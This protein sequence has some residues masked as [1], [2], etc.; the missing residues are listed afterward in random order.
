MADILIIKTPERFVDALRETLER[1]VLAG[2]I[3]AVIVI[4]PRNHHR[5]FGA[6][7]LELLTG[8]K[9]SETLA[10]LIQ[11]RLIV[12]IIAPVPVAINIIANH[13]EQVCLLPGELGKRRACLLFIVAGGN[14]NAT[15]NCR[16]ARQFRSV[17]CPWQRRS[18]DIFI[19]AIK[20]F[21]C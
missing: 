9:L 10:Q 15:D 5:E 16:L 17:W 1:E 21:D 12:Y 14:E 11:F 3:C 7:C 13:E 2:I 6:G 8:C 4:V 20:R 18:R 19:I